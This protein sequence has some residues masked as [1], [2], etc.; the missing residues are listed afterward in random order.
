MR[1]NV[2]QILTFATALND[3]AWWIADGLLLGQVTTGADLGVLPFCPA[4]GMRDVELGYVAVMSSIPLPLVVSLV[5]C[6]VLLR[7]GRQGHKKVRPLWVST[8]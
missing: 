2:A 8:H 4:A 7:I 1:V 3:L 5:L 6:L